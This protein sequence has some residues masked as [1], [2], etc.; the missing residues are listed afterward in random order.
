MTMGLSIIA[1]LAALTCAGQGVAQ[2]DP[3]GTLGDGSGNRTGAARS[4]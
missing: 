4:S 2:A 1:A 3:F